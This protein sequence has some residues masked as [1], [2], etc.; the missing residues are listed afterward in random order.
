MRILYLHQYFSTGEG[1]AAGRA[2]GFVKD[3]AD[4]GH[5][6]T[7]VTGITDR[8]NFSKESSKR[9]LSR[10][11]VENFEVVVT[12]IKYSNKL[13]FVGRLFSFVAYNMLALYFGIRIRSD[14]VFA[15]STP[16]TIAIPGMI[17]SKL[18]RKPFVF[19]VRDLWPDVPIELGSLNNPVLKTIAKKIEMLAY[20]SADK[21][22]VLT[23]SV[24]EI[25]AGKGIDKEKI[26][27]IPN[28]SDTGMFTPSLSGSESSFRSVNDLAGKFL[29]VH[30]GSMGEVNDLGFILKVAKRLKQRSDIS[31]VLIGDGK[32][33]SSLI[34]AKEA[35][36]LDNVHFFDPVQRT[37]L[38]EIISSSD[39]GVV[40]VKQVKIL[41]HNC[42]NK[43]FDYISA[44]IP[45]FL[46]YGG[47]M[48]EVVDEHQI[49]YAIEDSDV[50]KFANSL[51]ELM[52]DPE[53]YKQMSGNARK[54]A[55][56]KF[57]RLSMC[58][59]FEKVLVSA[60]K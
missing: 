47:W 30:A 52:N 44:G 55:V 34:E 49:G 40:T 51:L 27:L 43:F 53:K 48:K 18:K 35:G 10:K 60:A 38:S 13:S 24:R 54:L 15:T 59:N 20:R 4:K 32:Q 3:L 12:N 26:F 8:S 7:V 37:K 28:S 16:L 21:I 56:E 22:I 50:D 36:K 33:K 46:N 23:P 1:S 17:I 14:V 9:L 2:Y 41:E 39:I 58:D 19:E 31:F 45:V 25:I 6:V 29:V 57:N 11:K 42:A 5:K